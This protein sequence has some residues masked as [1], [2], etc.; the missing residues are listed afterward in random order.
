[1]DDDGLQELA[2][3][4]NSKAFHLGKNKVTKEGVAELQKQLPDCDI[5]HHAGSPDNNE[6]TIKAS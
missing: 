4:T 3:L 1:M 6:T 5:R 2:K